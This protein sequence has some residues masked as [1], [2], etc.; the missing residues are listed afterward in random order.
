MSQNHAI[1]SACNCIHMAHPS[2]PV[3]LLCI[4]GCGFWNLLINLDLGSSFRLP[5]VPAV[6][7]DSYL[8]FSSLW[9]A[10]ILPV[11]YQAY[12]F[13]MYAVSYLSI[14]STVITTLTFWSCAH[15][16]SAPQ[17]SF[18]SR[19]VRIYETWVGS[20][21]ISEAIH[22]PWN[23]KVIHNT[24][25]P[26][27]LCADLPPQGTVQDMTESWPGRDQWGLLLPKGLINTQE[28]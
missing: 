7:T 5:S 9:H 8:Q 10:Y 11:D 1:T 26:N 3:S 20:Y 19:I 13:K 16:G 6:I 12:C 18:D 17:S 14:T 22:I 4:A 23:S 27:S 28:G 21:S 25:I 15:K 2:M 24:P